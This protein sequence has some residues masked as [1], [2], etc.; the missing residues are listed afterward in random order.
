M[1]DH[2]EVKTRV[3]WV[4]INWFV[5]RTH[6]K[7][8]KKT[9]GTSTT[10][11]PNTLFW[12]AVSSALFNPLSSEL[13]FSPLL[14]NHLPIF[15]VY[16]SAT[17]RSVTGFD[18]VQPVTLTTAVSSNNSWTFDE[19]NEEHGGCYH[20]SQL[21]GGAEDKNF[22]RW[23]AAREKE[24]E[25]REKSGGKKNGIGRDTRQRRLIKA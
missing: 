11:G 13:F 16:I 21:V 6:G 12:L 15:L 23:D 1:D 5:C 10:V 18:W 14:E 20:L 24:I 8:Q 2:E 7:N 25:K 17:I 9:N 19:E 22:Y 3:C 4:H